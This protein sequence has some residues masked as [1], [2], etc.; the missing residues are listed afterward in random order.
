MT[1]HAL[2]EAWRRGVYEAIARRRDM[3]SFLPDPIAPDILARILSAAHQAGS[4]G[5]SQPWNFLV[6][7]NL[8]VRR[9][10]RSHVE[11]ERMR[12]ADGFEA[13]RRE[14]YLSFKLEGIVDAPINLCVTC[15][16]E[17]FGPAVIGRNTIPETALYS[18]CCA[19]QNLWLA[20]RA[21][22]VG[23]GWVSVLEPDV[24][25]KILGIPDRIVPV[26]YL[27]VGF[28]ESFPE[29]PMLETAGWL[30][31]LPLQEVTF[32][33]RWGQRP[34]PDLVRA[35]EM[36]GER[37]A[38]SEEMPRA[39]PTRAHSNGDEQ[40]AKVEPARKGL[41]LVYTGKGKGKT[42]AALG[43]VFRALGRGLRAAVVQFIKGKW[44]TGERLFAETIP[45]L[46]F[47]VMGQGFTW[48]SDDL[49]RDRNAAAEAWT[50]AK[51]LF[52]GGEH[53]VVVLDEIT[54]AINYGFIE[55]ADVLTA[56]RNRPAHVHVIVTGRNA[57]EE[58]C[59]LAD[60]VT[61][62]KSVKHPFERGLKAQ[63]GIDY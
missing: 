19:I 51:D 23:V 25:R 55:A 38:A 20:A 5:F 40:S 60:L 22:G 56:L 54:Y 13:E 48:E 50:K 8:E 29:R 28:V 44:K 39:A 9:E 7:E 57:P 33:D 14:K 10:I 41:L 15:D 53:V 6:V 61:E 63:P 42:T 30:P 45:G 16:Q 24:L 2:P 36:I 17:R 1:N 62:M 58:L 27:C 35:L 46:T 47:L 11:I 12:A 49:T 21:E 32:H 59:A 31:R 3:R 34:P 4:V 26:A 18:T 37:T 43:V 52:T